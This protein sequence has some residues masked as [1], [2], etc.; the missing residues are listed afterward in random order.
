[1][2]PNLASSGAF[3]AQAHIQQ[4]FRNSGVNPITDEKIILGPLDISGM[5]GI[6]GDMM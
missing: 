1:M 3:K 5:S 2:H 6:V 4:F